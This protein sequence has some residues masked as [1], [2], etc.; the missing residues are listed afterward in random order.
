[1]GESCATVWHNLAGR[2]MHTHVKDARRR[3]DGEWDLVL[4]EDGE[5]P[6]REAVGML[7]AGGWDGYL[8]VE[9][10]KKWHAEIPEPEVAFPQHIAVLRRY[11]SEA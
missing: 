7:K 1:M 5:V 2:L 4:L 6:V 9:W 3:P 11:V 8:V 10:E